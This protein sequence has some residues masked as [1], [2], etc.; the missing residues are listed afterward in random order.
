MNQSQ[1]DITNCA[2][3][4]HRAETTPNMLFVA[5]GADSVEIEGYVRIGH[6]VSTIGKEQWL[7][8]KQ[9]LFK[10]EEE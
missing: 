4:R 10:T 3:M 2:L 8:L 1:I 6:I 7:E 9:Q 5:C